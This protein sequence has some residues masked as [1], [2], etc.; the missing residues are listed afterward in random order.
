[1]GYGVTFNDYLDFPD[2]FN[3]RSP[4]QHDSL[5]PREQVGEEFQTLFSLESGIFS[6]LEKGSQETKGP[7]FFEPEFGKKGCVLPF[8][9]GGGHRLLV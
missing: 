5:F 8:K 7:I 1:M 9:N 2:F 6:F 3:P 4:V